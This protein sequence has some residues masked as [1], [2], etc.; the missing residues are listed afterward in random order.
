MV[1]KVR[2]LI[3]AHPDDEIIWFKPEIFDQIFIIFCNRD[4]KP[5]MGEMRRRSIED[6]PLKNIISLLDIDESGYWKDESKR[7]DYKKSKNLLMKALH[8]IAKINIIHEVYTHNEL[9]EYKHADHIL[10]HVCV[11][12]VFSKICPIWMPT[13]NLT[14]GSKIEYLKSKKI[15][16]NHSIDIEQYKKIKN[17]YISNASWTWSD[18]YLPNE[19]ES[20]Y[21][22]NKGAK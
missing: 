8:N 3:V 17:L 16:R 14:V 15:I 12:K 20:Y 1:R 5:L 6:H 13:K 2:V 22:T 9:G 21:C 10:V 19:I 18:S 7:Q 4:D 11:K